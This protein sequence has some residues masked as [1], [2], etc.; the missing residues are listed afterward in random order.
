MRH[1]PA[2]LVCAAL[3]IAASICMTAIALAEGPVTG[4]EHFVV[5][6]G[7]RLRIWEKVTGAPDGKPIA[8]LAHGSATAGQESFDL[9]VPGKPSFSFMDFLAGEGFDVFAPDI[10]GFGRSTKPE[11]GVSTQDA[12]ADLHAAI[13]YILAVRGADKVNLVAWSWG[14]QYAGLDVIAHPGTV[15]RYVAYAQM[16]KDSPDIITRRERLEVFRKSPYME[17]PKAAWTK[18]FASMTPE[19]ANDPAVIAAFG[20]AAASVEH[21]SPTGPHIDMTTLLPMVDPTRIS[22]PVMLIHGQYDDVADVPG[23]APFFAALA[24]PEKTY[25]IIPDAGHMAHLQAGHRQF[26][27]EIAAFLKR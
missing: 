9:Q 1:A 25:T 11:A 2:A 8:V 5:A 19:S 26:Q 6:N 4:K 23:L 12:A 13:T 3:H 15:A 21:K 17:I 10:R 16:H 22:V 14:T 27:K 7:V 18:R 20:S 24:T